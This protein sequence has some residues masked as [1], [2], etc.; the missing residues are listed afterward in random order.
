[1]KQILMISVPVT[2]LLA[3]LGKNIFTLFYKSAGNIEVTMFQIG[4][5]SIIL[6]SVAIYMYRLLRKMDL[7]L[8]LT[9]IPVIA[10]VIQ[11]IIMSVIV[12][13]P[14][15]GALSMII[16]EVVFWLVVVIMELLVCIKTL[17]QGF[18]SKI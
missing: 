18:K 11:T 5:I 7:K 15:I 1:M 16:S 2:V 17:K 14:E 12:K 4:S 10:F 9:L 13:V 8:I 3:V 6:V